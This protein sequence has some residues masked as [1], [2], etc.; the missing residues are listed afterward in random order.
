MPT[1][2][3]IYYSHFDKEQFPERFLYDIK[4]NLRPSPND[5]VLRQQLQKEIWQQLRQVRTVPDPSYQA[6]HS[7]LACSGEFVAILDIVW[8][9]NPLANPNLVQIGPSHPPKYE[10][11]SADPMIQ[12]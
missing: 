5:Q 6:V 10:Y 3:S 8:L 4:H 11:M 1:S 2:P 7:G 12:N 9:S